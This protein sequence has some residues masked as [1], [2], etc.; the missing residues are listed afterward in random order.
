MAIPVPRPTQPS[1]WWQQGSE[2]LLGDGLLLKRPLRPGLGLRCKGGNRVRIKH[3]AAVAG[4]DFEYREASVLVGQDAAAAL[5]IPPHVAA[6]AL[7]SM[8]ENEHAAFW[9]DARL[10]VDVPFDPLWSQDGFEWVEEGYGWE[11]EVLSV[12]LPEI[13]QASRLVLRG[14]LRMPRL[15]L[16]LYM[17]QPPDAYAAA[18]AALRTG[19]RLID[20][21]SMYQNEA[22]VGQALRDS[23]VPRAEVFVVS[24]VNTPDHGYQETLSAVQRSLGLLGLNRIDLVLIHSPLGGRILETWD[25][26]LEAQQRGWARQV[27]VSNFG[28]GHLEAIEAAG[29]PRPAVNQFELSPF[30]QE[31]VLREFCDRRG[32][33]VMGYS[34]LTRG[35]RL[36]DPRVGI[37]ARKYGRSPAQ[38]LIRWALQQGVASIP[39]TTR[40]ERLEEN[41]A[42]FNFQL[43][44]AD[45]AQL[46]GCEEN[47]HTCWDCLDVAWQG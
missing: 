9:L 39:K 11:V 6:A 15:G 19:Y 20:T 10:L 31:P 18:L 33:A 43:D 3:R 13:S 44:A 14:G 37:V 5:P 17:V 24:K 12:G 25:A 38:V 23:H 47:L 34:P 28:V 26:L 16:G 30:C 27:G 45:L 21:A 29:R 40:R 8:S 1:G 42:A 4:H 36:S 22:A 46:A 41:L 32:I 7:W 2:D 35:E